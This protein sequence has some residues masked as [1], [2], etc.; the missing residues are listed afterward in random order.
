MPGG[1]ETRYDIVFDAEFETK[2]GGLIASD[3]ATQVGGSDQILDLGDGQYHGVVLINV[4]A[5]EI[6][7]D[8]ELYEI[9][10]QGSTESDFADTIVNLAMLPLG[11][12]EVM[13]ANGDQDSA[14]GD[15]RLLFS[16]VWNNTVYQYFR[17]YV[18]V[19][20][21]IATGINFTAFVGRIDRSL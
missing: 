5:I 17:L 15:Y 16:N 19:S 21:T 20:G 7:S 18:D 8:D 11:A 9:Y 3:A 6:A 2:D 10:A 13:A 1:L 12:K 14:V 4:T